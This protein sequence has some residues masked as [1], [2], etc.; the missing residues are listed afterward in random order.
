M[1][2]ADLLYSWDPTPRGETSTPH[3]RIQID[4]ETLRD[5][6]QAAYVQRAPTVEERLQLVRH[7]T[8]LGVDTFNVGLPVTGPNVAMITALLKEVDVEGLQIEANVACRTV[9]SDIEPVA[10]I[11]QATGR[12]VEVCAFIGSSTIRHYAE[13]WDWQRILT[14][15]RDAVS[16]GVGEKLNVSFV[17][18]DT[19]RAHPD[20]LY[21]MFDVAVEA[22]ATR[23]ILCDTVGS[24]NPATVTKLVESI[25]SLIAWKGWHHIEIDWHGH[26]DR[27]LGLI[28]AL[29]AVAA[30]VN[31]I[32]TTALGVGERA[33]NV[34]TELFLVN[35]LLEK[36]DG[37]DLKDLPNYVRYAS[38]I[39]G[40]PIPVNYPGFGSGVFTTQT[41]VHAA[42]VEKARKTGDT[43]LTDSV[44]SGVPAGVIGRRQD[45]VV[46]PMSGK[47]NVTGFCEANGLIIP[48]TEQISEILARAR[49][50]GRIL[51]MDEVGSFLRVP[52]WVHA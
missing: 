21:E 46:G 3:R 29:T 23:L 5:G 19:A 12:P 44:Y 38:E 22:G 4:D 9:V 49:S 42:A 47:S 24:A 43:W 10:G 48:S 45:V 27:G 16:F 33:G 34:P 6:L 50:T 1:S 51:S 7:M 2:H 14:S 28:N 13:G 8:S 11:V 30:G 40:L 17:T 25:L 52:A 37:R 39:L 35:M 18:E 31:R 32:H 20:R 26:N 36:M 41:G 15:I